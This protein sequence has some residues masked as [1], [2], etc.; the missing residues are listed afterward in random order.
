MSEFVLVGA[1]G[2]SGVRHEFQAYPVGTHFLP[3][4]G[5]YAFCWHAPNGQWNTLYIGETDSFYRRLTAELTAHHQYERATTLGLSHIAVLHV[6]GD[7]GE[8]LSIETDL[9]HALSPPCND[10]PIPVGD[11]LRG[12]TGF[13]FGRR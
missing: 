10:Q 7:R 2:V 3:N 11:A 13:G 6:P 1:I 4:P 12:M 9:R 8:R 5:V